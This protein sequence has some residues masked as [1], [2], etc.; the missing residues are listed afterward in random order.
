MPLLAKKI[1]NCVKPITDLKADENVFT[2]QHTKEQFR[3]K[4]YPCSVGF[5]V[6]IQDGGAH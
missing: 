1:F 2:I 4:E 5:V 6:K 3:S